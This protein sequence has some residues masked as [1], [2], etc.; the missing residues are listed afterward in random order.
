MASV[1]KARKELSLTELMERVEGARPRNDFGARLL[2]TTGEPLKI[3]AEIK[4]A[5]PSK[6]LIAGGIN[7][8][9]VAREYLQGGASAISVLTEESYFKGSVSDFQLVRGTVPEMPLLRKDFI[10][11]EYQIYESVL[12]G[13]DAILLIVAALDHNALSRYIALSGQLG[14]S[15][16]VEVHA[17]EELD[18]ALSGGA[19]IIGVNN[20][21]LVT[22]EVSPK[23]SEKIAAR[24]PPG[25]VSVSE[26]G[27]SGLEGLRAA[28]EL[29]YHAVLIGEHFMRAT[30]RAGEV[31][32]LARQAGAP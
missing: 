3:I 17:E 22:F 27:I 14:L 7:P 11:D 30:D 13:A 5:S 19:A 21:N 28:A 25:V 20:R 10:V 15:A 4:R 18:A 1:E 32:K 29:G 26:S 8:A 16:L 24:I 23:A 9:D 12:I 31:R 6:G 2:R